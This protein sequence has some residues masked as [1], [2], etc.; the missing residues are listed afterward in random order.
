M[1]IDKNT[2][3][4]K[5]EAWNDYKMNSKNFF[6]KEEMEQKTET[7][8]SSEKEDERN[9]T[10]DSNP[11]GKVRWRKTIVWD[12]TGGVELSVLFPKE[13][14]DRCD[15]KPYIAWICYGIV[16]YAGGSTRG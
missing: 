12:Y 4:N 7:W 1:E 2:D 8:N 5:K 14:C 16:V 11:G 9:E 3:Q 15:S 10:I 6:M 13:A